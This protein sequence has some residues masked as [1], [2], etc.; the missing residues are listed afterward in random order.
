MGISQEYSGRSLTVRMTFLVPEHNQHQVTFILQALHKV[1][2][3][4]PWMSHNQVANIF[5]SEV[6]TGDSG[7]SL[8]P[9]KI[10]TSGE[11]EL[12]WLYQPGVTITS[13]Q[14]S[15]FEKYLSWIR[16]RLQEVLGVA[17]SNAVIHRITALLFD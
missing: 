2:S 13:A 1:A 16:D 5:F 4:R 9:D 10:I 8:H 11:H 17:I 3:E 12:R 15:S 14:E 7:T 6:Q